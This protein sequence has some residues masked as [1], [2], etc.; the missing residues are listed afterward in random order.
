MIGCR[1]DDLLSLPGSGNLDEE[2]DHLMR[3]NG[4][5]P[6]K[7]HPFAATV[8]RIFS[9]AWS[10]NSLTGRDRRLL[11]I[12]ALAG[13]GVDDMLTRHL[14]AALR[15]GDLNPGELRDAVAFLV[16]YLGLARAAKLH[17]LVEELID[18]CGET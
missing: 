10:L 9:E 12:G 2:V 7:H 15:T 3:I 5:E 17:A 1:T 8:E 13:L 11:L 6:G 14:D 18:R 16:P 4:G